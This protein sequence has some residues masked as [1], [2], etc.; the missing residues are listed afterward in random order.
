[1][2]DF[3]LLIDTNIV[4]GLED[5]RPV[6][7]GLADLLR[8]CGEHGV[9][10]FVQDANYD[11]VSRDKD[12]VR[13][14][15]TLSKL[16]K[17]QRLHGLPNRSDDDLVQR[18]GPIRHEN[19]RRGE[20]VMEKPLAN[21][22]LPVSAKGI[23]VSDRLHYPTFHDHAA[24]KKFVLPIRPDYHQRLFPEIAFGRELPLF[25]RSQFGPL[26][27]IQKERTP[28]NTIRKV[29]LCRAKSRAITAGDLVFFYL[30]KSA[31]LEAS[32]C[33]TTVGVVEQ[34]AEVASGDD[35]VRQTAK[36]SVFSA[37]QIHGMSAS[38]KAPVKMI[39]FL[40]VGHLKPQISLAT[41]IE[42]KVLDS[43][44]PQS[45]AQISEQKYGRLRPL[46]DL[47]FDV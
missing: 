5:A 40:L 11:D 42:R 30:S 2:S 14:A 4:I 22:A 3:K 41:L 39:D 43:R 21:G 32:Q 28:G 25:P 15:V 31:S 27:A 45:I 12:P 34:V 38:I 19:D 16:S 24:V 6:Q 1:M 10:V 8:R 18:F 36:R 13:R 37:E 26:L 17:F 33:V 44:P 7:A 9:G 47:G 29:Y 35:L 46:L 20:L 23:F